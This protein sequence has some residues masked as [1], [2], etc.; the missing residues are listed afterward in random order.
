[1]SPMARIHIIE[2]THGKGRKDGIALR[3]V[4]RVYATGDPTYTKFIVSPFF[5]SPRP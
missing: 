4:P 1:M 2:V 3:S 5:P